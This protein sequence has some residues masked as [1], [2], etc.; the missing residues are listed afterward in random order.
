MSFRTLIL[1]L[2]FLPNISMALGI[3]ALD[4][5][6]NDNKLIATTSEKII[7]ISKNKYKY[8]NGPNNSINDISLFENDTK[9][10]VAMNQGSFTTFF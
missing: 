2:L 10:L 6:E 5:I 1:M 4:W 3:L 7:T 9:L 8:Y